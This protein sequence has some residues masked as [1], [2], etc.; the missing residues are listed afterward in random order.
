[1][2]AAGIYIIAL[3]IQYYNKK[4]IPKIIPSESTRK[5]GY[6]INDPASRIFSI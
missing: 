3:S 1:V 4:F 6:D 2:L 5:A